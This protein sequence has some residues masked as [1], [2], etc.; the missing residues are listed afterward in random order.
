MHKQKEKEKKPGD[1]AKRSF[2]AQN[3]T[4]A[5]P[6]GSHYQHANNPETHGEVYI[7]QRELPAQIGPSYDSVTVGDNISLSKWNGDVFASILI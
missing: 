4:S 3:I 1:G 6:T 5:V 7:L 2:S